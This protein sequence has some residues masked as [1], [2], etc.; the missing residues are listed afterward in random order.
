MTSAI[1]WVA[2]VAALVAARWWLRDAPPAVLERAAQAGLVVAAVYIG[3]DGRLRARQHEPRSAQRPRHAASRPRTS[4]SAPAPA[5][6]FGGDVVVVTRDEYCDG[7][8]QLA[9]GAAREAVGRAHSA[10]ARRRVR[11]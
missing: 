4:W 2:G 5:D 8:L 6:P 7:S 11:S 9:H 10:A 3:R 1:V